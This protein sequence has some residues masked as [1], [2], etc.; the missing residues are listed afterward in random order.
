MYCCV[1]TASVYAM[2]P[3]TEFRGHRACSRRGI[4]RDFVSGPEPLQRPPLTA[5][6]LLILR[7]TFL[8]WEFMKKFMLNKILSTLENCSQL[9]TL[10]GT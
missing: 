3:T 7:R 4:R 2:S 1:S 5:G 9:D 6:L 8:L 10:R